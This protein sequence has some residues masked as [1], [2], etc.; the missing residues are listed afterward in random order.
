MIKF[1]IRKL[2]DVIYFK[3][4]SIGNHGIF[5][6][7][8]HKGFDCISQSF[9]IKTLSKQSID[10]NY[11]LLLSITMSQIT[12]MLRIIINIDYLTLSEVLEF[13]L[14]GRFWLRAIN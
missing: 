10:Y 2:V 5:S 12:S 13:S 11:P 8:A 4:L 14:S 3:R 1:D 6:L 7:G 9:F